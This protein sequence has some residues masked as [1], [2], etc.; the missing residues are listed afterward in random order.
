[1]RAFTLPGG[2]GIIDEFWIK[3][4]LKDP[5]NGVMHNPVP[6]RRHTN[7]PF[8]GIKNLEIPVFG[9]LVSARCQFF[10]EPDACD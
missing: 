1:M 8:L 3:Y 2:I 9:R 7:S 4:R 10:F 6:E 5:Y